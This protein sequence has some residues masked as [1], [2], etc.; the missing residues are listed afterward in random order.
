MPELSR[1]GRGTT[2][3]RNRMGRRRIHEASARR[4]AGADQTASAGWP[5]RPAVESEPWDG[6]RRRHGEASA[7]CR[8]RKGKKGMQGKE[9][10]GVLSLRYSTLRAP[11]FN[12]RTPMNQKRYR[13]YISS[14]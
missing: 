13:E 7:R 11:L 3:S 10:V 4:E 1:N 9:T 2:A 8:G 5:R 6:R 12:T 14:V